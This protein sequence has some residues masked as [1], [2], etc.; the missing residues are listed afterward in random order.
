MLVRDTDHTQFL[1][2][3]NKKISN[4]T[5]DK[6]VEKQGTEHIC[7]FNICMLDA[8]MDGWMVGWLDG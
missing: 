7:L 4:I 3:V 6:T 2:T 8:W 1:N 5:S